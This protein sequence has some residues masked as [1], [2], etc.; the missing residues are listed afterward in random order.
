MRVDAETGLHASLTHHL[1]YS[2]VQSTLSR[3]SVVCT[4][5]LYAL[6]Y[7]PQA[8]DGAS[9]QHQTGGVVAIPVIGPATSKVLLHT[10]QRRRRYTPLCEQDAAVAVALSVSLSHF[11]RLSSSSS[12]SSKY[13]P[14]K[15]FTSWPMPRSMGCIWSVLLLGGT[16]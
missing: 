16:Y 4:T 1:Q 13:W 11:S 15:N 6:Q 8:S 7:L 3:R 14:T 9:G 2:P 12:H 10:R 5:I